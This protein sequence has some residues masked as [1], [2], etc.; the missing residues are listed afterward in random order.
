M[1][2]YRKEAYKY[3][4]AVDPSGIICCIG[5]NVFSE[6]VGNSN[7]FID[8]KTFKLSDLDL[9]FVA[10][11]SGTLKKNNFRNPERQLVRY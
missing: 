2:S 10:T 6:I 8:G 4:S 11:N 7:D 3:Y 1:H 9:E 5:S